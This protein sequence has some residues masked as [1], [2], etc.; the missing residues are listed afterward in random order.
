VTPSV[1]A[2]GEEQT[3]AVAISSLCGGFVV[4]WSRTLVTAMAIPISATLRPLSFCL[5]RSFSEPRSLLFGRRRC[6]QTLPHPYPHARSALSFVI[7]VWRVDRSVVAHPQQVE[8]NRVLSHGTRGKSRERHN[9]I[10]TSDMFVEVQ[11]EGRVMHGRN[12]ESDV[13]PFARVEKSTTAGGDQL[14]TAGRTILQLVQR[15]AGV[16]D[17]NSRHALGMAQTLSDQLRA[18]EDRIAELEAE[19][20][21]Y[22]QRADRAE[23]WL[24]RVY[25]EIED[26]FLPQGDSPAR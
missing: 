10:P 13:I 18:A 22:Q 11:R 2:D 9:R 4:G 3:E 23:Q 26:R 15:A 21:A 19:I 1:R 7:H 12:S 6:W 8:T 14:D 16:A 17:E 5:I 20:T 25:T 24:H